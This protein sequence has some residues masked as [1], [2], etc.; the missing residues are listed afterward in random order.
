MMIHNAVLLIEKKYVKAFL[1]VQVA[2]YACG[3]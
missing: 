1:T 3:Y 2:T